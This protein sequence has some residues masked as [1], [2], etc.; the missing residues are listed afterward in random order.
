LFERKKRRNSPG[1]GG[2]ATGEEREEG[3]NHCWKRKI[4]PGEGG[5]REVTSSSTGVATSLMG[6]SLSQGNQLECLDKGEA[7]Q[8]E[9][10][11]D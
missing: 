10:G 11:E 8:S 1:L 6:A 7:G 9:K 3:G 5:K 2:W 4:E